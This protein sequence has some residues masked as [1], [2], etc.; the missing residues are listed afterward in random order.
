MKRFLRFGAKPPNEPARASSNALAMALIGFSGL[1]LTGMHVGVRLL[2]GDLHVFEIVFVRNVIGLV[3]L[4]GWFGRRGV[5][6]L[7]T[8]R[9]ALHGLRN[10]LQVLSMLTFFSGLLITP[11]AQVNALGFTSPLF[12]TL[13]AV[14]LLGERLPPR[15]LAVLALGILGTLIIIRPGIVPLSTGP[16]LLLV[17]SLFWGATLVTIKLL[18]RTEST[19]TTIFYMAL[20]LTPLSFIFAVPVW[21]WPTAE[22]FGWLVGIAILGTAAH[23]AL[24]QSFRLADATVVLPLDFLKLIWGSLWGFLFFAEVPDAMT[25]VG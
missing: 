7:H 24:N 15:R 14:L 9:I 1:C 4:L 3:M 22:Q 8:R 12:A 6:L 5:G 19:A 11:L 25:W 16:L 21:Q 13:L 23:I 2:P 20:I 18:S 10:L 17:S